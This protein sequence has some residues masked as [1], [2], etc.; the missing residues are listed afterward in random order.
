MWLCLTSRRSGLLPSRS[1]ENLAL[2]TEAKVFAHPQAAF[3]FASARGFVPSEALTFV[4]PD[5]RDLSAAPEKR[6]YRTL[7]EALDG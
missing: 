7:R 1:Q 6:D 5:D 4:Y 2:L 3:Y